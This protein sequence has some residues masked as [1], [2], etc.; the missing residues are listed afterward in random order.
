MRDNRWNTTA[1]VLLRILQFALGI[2][3]LGGS[4]YFASKYDDWYIPY[5]IVVSAFTLSWVVVVL[6]LFF[7]NKLPPLLAVTMDLILAVSYIVPIAT[8][9]EYGPNGSS[10]SCT[11]SGQSTDRMMIR[12]CATLKAGFPVLVIQMLTFTGAIIW[13]GKVLYQNRN[14][15]PNDVQAAAQSARHGGG[16][17]G[18]QMAGIGKTYWITGPIRVTTLESG[19]CGACGTHGEQASLSPYQPANS[20]IYPAQIASPAT[21][22]NPHMQPHFPL[23]MPHQCFI[24]RHRECQNCRQDQNHLQQQQTLSHQIYQD[25]QSQQYQLQSQHQNH[26]YQ[27]NREL[28]QE[29]CSIH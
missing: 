4:A 12:G 2:V 16:A 23:A 28:P 17:D 24:P 14:G 21:P 26:Q 15:G 19:G 20:S 7:T 18:G 27:Q 3:V 25:W 9:A 13:D 1:F 22:L 11:P 29:I 8:I 6:S 5:T 10:D